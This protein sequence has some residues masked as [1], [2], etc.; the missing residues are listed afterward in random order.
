MKGFP[1]IL[2]VN[3][4]DN[5]EKQYYDTVLCYLR[6]ALYEHIISNDENNY[7]DLEK[8]YFLYFK[9]K[10][11]IQEILKNLSKV[12]IVELENIGWKCKVSFGGTALFIYSSKIPSS[13]WDDEL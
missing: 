9:D 4:K 3:N 10:K 6:K 8:F 13:C 2:N 1:L 7:F 5:F 11:N 12:V